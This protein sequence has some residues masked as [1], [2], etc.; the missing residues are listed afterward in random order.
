MRPVH[1]H[2]VLREDCLA[3][4]GMSANALAKEL[5]LPTAP[6]NDVVR[7]DRLTQRRGVARLRGPRS[8]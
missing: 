2:E 4:L 7:G 3:P 8:A 5:Y 6:I 1:P